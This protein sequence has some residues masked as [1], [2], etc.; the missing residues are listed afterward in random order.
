MYYVKYKK[1]WD[2]KTPMQAGQLWYRDGQYCP[3]P[4]GTPAYYEYW[5]EQISYIHNGFKWEGQHISGLNYLYLNYCPIINKKEKSVMMPDFWALDAEYWWHLQKA[6]GLV[7]DPDP[8]RP[9]IFEVSKTRQ[10]GASLKNVVPILYNMCFVAKSQ[11][12]IGSYLSS[13]TSKTTS[14]FLEYFYHAQRYTEFGKR[15]IKKERNEHYITGYFDKVDGE[16]L[17]SGFQSELRIITWKDSPEKGVGGPCDLFV[18]EEAGLHPTLLTSLE[19]ISPACKDG[20][21]TT[22]NIIVFG[23]AGKEG[24]CDD[25]NKLHHNPRAYDAVEFDNVWEPD[26]YF[27]KTG[28]FI[29][30]YS[31]R[32]GHMDADGNPDQESAIKKRDEQLKDLEKKDYEKYLLKLSQSP[33]KPSEMFNSRGRKRFHQQLLR[34]QIAFVESRGIRGTAVDLFEDPVTGEIEKLLVDEAIKSPIRAFPID[35][36]TEKEGC[37]E[38]FEFPD[39]YP[40]DNLYIGGIDSYNQEDSFYSD[41]LG[42]VFIYKKIHSLG[43]EGTYQ[44]PVAEYTGRPQSKYEFYR[45]CAYLARFYNATLMLENEDQEAAPWFFNNNYE[46]LLADQPDLIRQY[47]PTSQVKRKKGIHAQEQLIIAAENKIARYITDKIGDELDEDGN[48]VAPKFGVSRILSLGLLYE[49]LNYVHDR[50]K[51]FDRVRAFGWT[52]LYEDETAQTTA[53]DINDNTASFLCNTKRFGKSKN[54][55]I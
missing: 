35:Q 33:N 31:C 44:I 30:N 26:S 42:S 48:V 52:L 9:V 29:P 38:I 20:D 5:D 28:Y 14:M 12:Y 13:D 17:P 32:K 21:Y 4:E 40:P 54:V 25:L 7:A 39:R 43:D 11:N 53:S 2:T 16:V 18:V 1:W 37:I 50:N 27:K 45:I 55:W 10:C 51:N 36:R 49:L 23:A 19:F 24:Q 41:S 46:H 34:Q 47:L 15:F 3:F 22:G 6:L 8:Y